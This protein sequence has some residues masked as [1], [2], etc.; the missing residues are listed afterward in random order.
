MKKNCV[1]EGECVVC[2][3]WGGGCYRYCVVGVCACVD[4][5]GVTLLSGSQVKLETV[6]LFT[7]TLDGSAVRP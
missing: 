4:T 5:R 6:T 2:V 3:C 7:V 1:R